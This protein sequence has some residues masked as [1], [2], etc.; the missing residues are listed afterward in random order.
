MF[1]LMERREV[2][3]L[4]AWLHRTPAEAR[5][6][7]AK[8]RQVHGSPHSINPDGVKTMLRWCTWIPV[9][10][11]NG[12]ERRVGREGMSKE[13]VVIMSLIA[14]SQRRSTA[15]SVCVPN[16]IV[17]APPLTPPIS[18]GPCPSTTLPNQ[19]PFSPSS[20]PLHKTPW[21][22]SSGR[23]RGCSPQSPSAPSRRS[24]RGS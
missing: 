9:I 23:P 16:N 19:G 4:P 5:R 17:I 10:E 18:L 11:W 20:R 2:P 21:R 24:S 12:T 22:G 3:S 15:G 8:P 7:S 13:Y 6:R 14:F 1:H